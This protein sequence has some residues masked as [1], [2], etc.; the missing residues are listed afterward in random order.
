MADVRGSRPSG[1]ATLFSAP[2]LSGPMLRFVAI[3]VIWLALLRWS[4][5]IYRTPDPYAPKRR[6]DDEKPPV[7]K[8]V[9]Q[10]EP[11]W[12]RLVSLR[13]CSRFFQMPDPPQVDNPQPR[14]NDLKDDK[15]R[16]GK[17][18][19]LHKMEYELA[20]ARYENIY[21]AIWQNF[22]YMAVIAGGILTFGAKQVDGP[23]LYML[24]LSPLLLWFF[25][26]WMPLN[27]YGEQARTRL[28]DI[29]GILNSLY[30][31]EDEKEFDLHHFRHYRR[32][33]AQW[34]AKEVVGLLGFVITAG[35]LLSGVLAGDH[36]LGQYLN[37]GSKKPP[38]LLEI[39]IDGLN[40]KIDDPTLR[41]ILDSVATSLRRVEAV[42]S[43]AEK[44]LGELESLRSKDTIQP[45]QTQPA[46]TKP[47]FDTLHKADSS[48]R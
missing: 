42:Q 5:W 16:R 21:R 41:A 33:N 34:R 24:A 8:E 27:F 30:F 48:D 35:W 14:R 26:T 17:W 3:V 1:T 10:T 20:A 22:S 7:Q 47:A 23:L 15:A 19:D 39:G 45:A 44:R 40:V 28:A 6:A 11:H 18:Y 9:L 37:P 43:A 36:A 4:V 46:P 31:R 29:E 13:W 38:K 12:K 32:R 2:N 25:A